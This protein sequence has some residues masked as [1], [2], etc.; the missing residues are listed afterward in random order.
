[1]S[2]QRFIHPEIW[3]SEQFMSL[4]RDARLMFIGIISTSDDHG[5]RKASAVSLKAGLMACD[6]VTLD[7]VAEWRDEIARLGMIRLYKSVDGVELM[8]IPTWSKY[9]KPKYIAASKIPEFPAGGEIDATLPAKPGHSRTTLDETGKRSPSGVVWSG[10]EKSGVDKSPP[11]ED[12]LPG[13]VLRAA[14]DL[15][16]ETA[17]I[18]IKWRE[19]KGNAFRNW[20]KLIAKVGKVDA[21]DPVCLLAHVLEIQNSKKIKHKPATLLARLQKPKPGMKRRVPADKWFAE[22]KVMLDGSPADREKSE[23]QSL[24]EILKR[25]K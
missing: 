11:S 25:V 7:E 5:R 21:T 20:N 22:A 12:P 1:M 4:T 3:T 17:G 19:G 18:L 13:D 10:V 14:L 23:P 2:R 6:T 9:Q 24:D 15:R 16:W 8:D